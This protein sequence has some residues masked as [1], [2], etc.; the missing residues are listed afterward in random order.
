MTTILYILVAI[1]LIGTL[2]TLFVGVFAMGRG[3]AFNEKH[4]NKLM[5]LR[6]LFQGFTLIV[7]ILLMLQL[8]G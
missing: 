5:R 8:R 6:I 2:G 4:G 3:G 1:G 7:F